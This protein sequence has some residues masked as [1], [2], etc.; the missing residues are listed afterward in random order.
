M[1][2]TDADAGAEL[3]LKGA[4]TPQIITTKAGREYLITPD[5]SGGSNVTDVS[6]EGDQLSPLPNW[7]EQAVTVQTTESLI[8]YVKRFGGNDTVLFADID[9]N[10]IVAAL[11][12]HDVEDAKRVAHRATLDLPYS[13]EWKVWTAIDGKLMEQLE[14]ARFLE[15]NAADITAPDAA[16]LLET[17][18]DLQA[19][20][21]VN[22]SKAVRTASDNESF[23]Y[24]EETTATSKKG[25]VEL[26]SR[27][28]LR[29]PVYFG[30]QAYSVAAFLRW[31]LE[32]GS[33]KLGIQ[34]HNREHVRQTVFKD[35]VLEASDKTERPAYFGRI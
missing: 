16:E 13:V 11:D 19:R 7:I 30:G 4:V 28:L 34:I 25:D 20:R 12:Y 27:F 17:C 8:E 23:E 22:F 15:E 32:E 31:R 9:H 2:R 18:R 24:S 6:E 1:D 29:L 26:P 5:E 35:L 3:A 21:K 33:L 14:F 10:R